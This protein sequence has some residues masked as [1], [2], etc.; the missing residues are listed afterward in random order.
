M[1]I[2]VTSRGGESAIVGKYAAQRIRSAIESAN[3]YG[4]AYVADEISDVT[5][6][7]RMVTVDYA[8]VTEDDGTELWAGWLDGSDR[9]APA[10]ASLTTDMLTT[11]A[12]VRPGDLVLY[13][14]GLALVDTIDVLEQ[15]G[16]PRVLIAYMSGRPLGFKAELGESFRFSRNAAG[17]TGV[18]RGWKA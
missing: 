14:S 17:M 10:E 1:K 4:T 13:E 3:S 8:V 9:P 12:G 11:W 18:R 7:R 16:S 2:H 5:D 6:S 15:V